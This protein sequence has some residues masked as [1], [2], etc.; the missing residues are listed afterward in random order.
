[1]QMK[2]FTSIALLASS[3]AYAETQKSYDSLTDYLFYKDD[4]LIML[5]YL[6]YSETT[7]PAGGIGAVVQGLLQPQTTLVLTGF[8]GLEQDVT[9]NGEETTE[10]FK[11]GMFL[12]DNF[13]I[14]FTDRVFFSALGFWSKIPKKNFYFDSSHDSKE[15]D[16]F[17]S[18]GTNNL[19][20]GTF[21]Y[22]FPWGEGGENP[23]GHHE[24]KDGFAMNREGYGGGMPFVT[25]HTSLGLN[26]FYQHR[27]IDN[28]VGVLGGTSTDVPEK[29]DSTGVRVF[30]SH[31]NTDFKDNPSRGYSLF[32]QYTKDFGEYES[33]QSWDYLEFKASQYFELDTF[34]FTQQNVLALNFWTA[35]SFSWE[36]DNEILPSIDA[37]QPPMWEGATLGGFTRMRGYD[38][39]RFAD[40][41]AIYATAE[42]RMILNYNPVKEGLFGEWIARNIPLDWFQV[43]GFVEAGRVHDSYDSELLSDMKYDAGLSLRSMAAKLPIRFDIAYGDEGVQTWVMV[44][45]PFDL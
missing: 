29:W 42:Y 36:N 10:S 14:P 5:P 35:Y 31:D 24:I 45:H 25:G 30:L 6:F 43:V 21:T 37:H 17:E 15:S 38:S 22:V 27:T 40:K 11:G 16:G 32:L 2:Q 12:F 8:G 20:M 41:A 34:S 7:G 44:K 18:P 4:N 28:Y 33:L 3:L 39:G 23:E 1:M 13:K 26:L 9:V 19:I